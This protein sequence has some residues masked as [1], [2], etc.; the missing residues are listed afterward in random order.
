MTLLP[1]PLDTTSS[2]NRKRFLGF[3]DAEGFDIAE[4]AFGGDDDVDVDGGGGCGG[5]GGGGGE[6]ATAESFP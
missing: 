5:G 4:F 1:S 6:S 3:E 2:P